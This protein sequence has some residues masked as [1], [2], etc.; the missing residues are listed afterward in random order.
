MLVDISGSS[1]RDTIESKK[2]YADEVRG[3]LLKS[4]EID[5]GGNK[6]LLSSHVLPLHRIVLSSTVAGRV[7]FVRQMHG[8]EMVVDSEE[9]VATE[10][11]RFGFR[12]LLYPTS[13]TEDGSSSL[14]KVLIP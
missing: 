5:I 7:A 6:F 8:V 1:C 11:I 2:N 10:L 12:V 14:G 3:E 9:K 4:D 13:S